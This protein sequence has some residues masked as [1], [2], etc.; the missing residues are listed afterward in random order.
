[1]SNRFK[2]CT[3]MFL[4]FMY[5]AVF[6]SQLAAYL[7]NIKVEGYMVPTIMA[8][9]AWGALLSPIIGMVADRMM[10]AE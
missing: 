4:Q 2:L 5:I 3:M 10:N 7:T 1:M 8:T 6:F 9:M